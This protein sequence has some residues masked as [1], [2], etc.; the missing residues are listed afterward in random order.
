[1]RF[2]SMD[3]ELHHPHWLVMTRWPSEETLAVSSTRRIWRYEPQT[4]GKQNLLVGA[5]LAV[6]IGRLFLWMLFQ[7]I[8]DSFLTTQPFQIWSVLRPSFDL[9]MEREEAGPTSAWGSFA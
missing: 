4:H 3:V 2:V 8:S 9:R 1:V 5:A 7:D 6:V